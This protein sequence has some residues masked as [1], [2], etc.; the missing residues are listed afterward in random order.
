MKKIVFGILVSMLMIFSVFASAT[1]IEI[2]KEDKPKYLLPFEIEDGVISSSFSIA[3]YQIKNIQGNDEINLE[4]FGRLL[5]AGKPDIPSK[6]FSIAIPPGSNFID[7]DYEIIN[8]EVLTGPY[9]IAPVP[10][11]KV[12]G[13]VN[14][15]V[16]RKEQ[17]DYEKNYQSIY[18][19]D[20]GY[21]ESTVS[22]LRTAG[23]RNYNLVQVR[24]N[25][26]TYYPISKKL[27]YNSEIKID[28]SYSFPEGYVYNER[29]TDEVSEKN[30]ERIIKNHEQAKEWYVEGKAGRESYEYVI[31][32]LDSL[33][34][35]INDLVDWEEAKGK[36]VYVA[37]TDWVSSNYDG[38][39]LAEEMRNFLRDKYPAEEWG[40]EYVCL[41]GG[42]ND[43]PMRLTAQNAGYGRPKTDYYY[44]ELSLPDDQSWDIDGDHQY[45]ENS[46]PID[47]TAEVS[48]GRIP[49]SDGSTVED[50][51]EKTVTYEQTND[52]SYKKNILLL[53][54]FFWPDTD[55]AV[56]M[57]YKTD[58]SEHPWMSDWTMTKLYEQGQSTYPMDYNLDYNNVKDVWSD[59]TFAFVNWAGHGSPTACYEYYP[60]QA[61]VDTDTCNYLDDDY[62]AIIFADACS[63]SDTD[64]DNIGQMMLKQGGVGF[65]G[66]T[67]VAYGKPGWNDPYDGS[68]QS[69]DYFFT[70]CCTSCDYTQGEAHQYG[71]YE[72]YTNSLWYYNKYET[73]EWGALWGNPDLTMGIVSQPPD[74]PQTPVGPNE[75]PKDVS[76]TFETTT[77]DPDGDTIYYMFDWGDGTDSGWQGPYGSGQTV[78]ENHIWDEYGSYEIKAKA[79]DIN[80]IESDWSGIKTVDI[81]ENA[82]PSPP[83]INGP[84]MFKAQKLQTYQL[85]STDPEGHN[86]YY[87]I[88]WGDGDMMNYEGPFESAE[89]AEFSHAWSSPGD[90]TII[91]KAMDEYGAKSSQSQIKITVIKS[92]N[93]VVNPFFA[94]FLERLFDNFPLL[95]RILI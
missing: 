50:I 47:F 60:S 71:L 51:C 20:E 12:I 79:K 21:P 76:A 13:A 69:L 94:K 65:L 42:Y 1:I 26:F 58:P 75:W 95:E 45:G 33:T 52:D 87:Q 2:N 66:A 29:V 38:Y 91:T 15:E 37:T 4:N 84:T 14:P 7:M 49:W 24:I 78:D 54:A 23:Y 81:V 36:N 6:I 73:F 10:L 88:L 43:V 25:P 48:V 18:G 35:K 92:R 77:T 86:I 31:I 55:N 11:P 8:S 3:E 22:F 90:Y 46:D 28:I 44:A 59:D 40:I 19:T 74:I 80:G 27:V 61:F 16:Q 9:N 17:D 67:K 41:I 82:A 32:T 53:G 70:T 83:T 93:I 64:D 72:M 85:S 62:P 63:N 89:T 56:L 5:I 30:S 34:S 68:S 39:D 57:E